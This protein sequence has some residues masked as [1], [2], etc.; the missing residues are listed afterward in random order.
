M[1]R[2]WSKWRAARLRG[3]ESAGQW[4]AV[5][6][7]SA[8][9]ALLG[10]LLLS[11]GDDHPSKSDGQMTIGK[12]ADPEKSIGALRPT[13]PAYS[14]TNPDAVVERLEE[15]FEIQDRAFRDRDERILHSVFA[16]DCRCLAAGQERIRAL[17]GDELRWVGY[18]SRVSDAH[19]VRMD[20]RTWT[21]TAVVSAS[22]TRVETES[23][24]VLRL[25]PAGRL[26][27]SFV[28]TQPP[29][30]GPLLLSDAEVVP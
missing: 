5:V 29:G 24:E 10:A 16:A 13:D 14:A 22:R 12:L 2:S 15:I 7:L 11:N 19:A 21:V 27:W 28:L 17:R 9:A 18:R 1:A 30:D 8:V 20:V 3:Y 6:A 25:I 4:V 23:H 26:R